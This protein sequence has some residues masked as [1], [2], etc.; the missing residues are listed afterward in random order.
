MTTFETQKMLD[1]TTIF[2]SSSSGKYPSHLKYLTLDIDS[3]YDLNL[4]FYVPVG[5]GE[6]DDDL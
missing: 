4:T 5:L 2:T 1:E 3:Q 6:D